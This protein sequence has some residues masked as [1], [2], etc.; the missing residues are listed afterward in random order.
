MTSSPASHLWQEGRNLLEEANIPQAGQESRDLLAH[1][2]EMTPSTLWSRLAEINISEE[3]ENHF[4]SLITRRCQKEPFHYLIGEIPFLELK[5]KLNPHVL[6]PRPETEELAQI[7]RD[8]LPLEDS[9]KILDLCCGSG[10]LGLSLKSAFRGISLTLADISARALEIAGENAQRLGLPAECIQSDLGS[11]LQGSWNLI[12]CNPPY[13]SYEQMDS[14]EPDVLDYEPHIALFC[15]QQGLF[16]PRR[17]LDYG[18]KALI[19]D[20]FMALEMDPSQ[21]EILAQHARELGFFTQIRQDFTGR[22]RF[23][24]LRKGKPWL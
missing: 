18:A 17:S 16:L 1:L 2:M 20:G 8:E 15:G 24:L 11:H 4:L 19:D 12:V 5:L 13:L 14:M 22:D 23:L 3:Q 10:C 9:W 7:L 6:I 21:S